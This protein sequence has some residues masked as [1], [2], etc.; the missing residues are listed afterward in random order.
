[1]FLT[2]S[3]A[4]AR[5]EV[6]HLLKAFEIFWFYLIKAKTDWNDNEDALVLVYL[7]RDLVEE[8]I[9]VVADNHAEIR[10]WFHQLVDLVKHVA[11]SLGPIPV[12]WLAAMRQADFRYAVDAK[13]AYM[14][15]LDIVDE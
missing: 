12:T 14:L 2:A 6:E 10:K 9:A 5:F 13:R 11:D 1:M 4:T 8:Y 3:D 15:T 7:L